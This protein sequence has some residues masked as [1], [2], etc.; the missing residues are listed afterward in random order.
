[1]ELDQMQVFT[2]Q[3]WPVYI[4]GEKHY[5][6]QKADGLHFVPSPLFCEVMSEVN[7]D[8]LIDKYLES[9]LDQKNVK[10]LMISSGCSLDR[11]K[12]LFPEEKIIHEV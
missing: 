11:F 10:W 6:E 8:E 5:L 9:E 2:G 12:E 4:S 3:V 7:V 1:M